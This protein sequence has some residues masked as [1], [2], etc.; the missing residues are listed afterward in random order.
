[1]MVHIAFGPPELDE[2]LALMRPGDILTHCYTGLTMKLVD[3]EGRL[4][5]SA[6]RAWDAGVVMDVGHGTG[7]FSFTSAEA[8]IAIGRFP[9][10]ISSDLHQ[11][12]VNGPAYN[13]PT[14]MSKFLH[15]GMSI[16]EVVRATTSR[17]AEVLKIDHQVGSL[18]EG[19]VADIAL[20]RLLPGRFPVYDI[21][22]EMREAGNL[23][24]NTLTIVGGRPLAPLPAD[25]PAPW[26]V[27]PVW[28]DAQK[29]FTEKQ[30]ALRARGHTPEAMRAGAEASAG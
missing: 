22:G 4:H 2:I 3:D 19:S 14:V 25:A 11:L 12:S 21:A 18:R 9:D 20:F 15:L 27:D 23:L 13:L 30:Q 29:P 26:A 16:G 8:L 28:P 7:S 1:M 6:R 5:D 17:P 24:V 10:V